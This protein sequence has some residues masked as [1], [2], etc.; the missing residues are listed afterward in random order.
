LEG[1]AQ[2]RVDELRAAAA[3]V[4][5]RMADACGRAGRDPETVE[6]LPISKSV[7]VARLQAAVAAGLTS[8]GENRVQE[9][10]AKA[11]VLP[12]VD[13]QMVGHLQSNK[14][15]LAAGLF[16]VVHSVD[17]PALARRLAGAHHGR[18]DLPLAVY[19]QVNV[20]RD[21]DKFGFDPDELSGVL[22]ELL[23]TADLDIRGLMTV[24]RLVETPAAARPTFTALRQLS[25]A[26]RARSPGLGAGL[27]MGMSDDFEI[28]VEEGATV[29]RIGRALFGERPA[30]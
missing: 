24:G 17:S 13:W 7:P 10:R 9:A 21:P 3:A 25:E 18:S 23:S 4:R 5:R 22:P 1:L 30:A 11:A 15:A 26:L 14:A 27:S 16:S 6:L 20:D 2:A 19:L 28:A 29:V 12:Q 8:F